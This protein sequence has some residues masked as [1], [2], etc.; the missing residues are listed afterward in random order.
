MTPLEDALRELPRLDGKSDWND[1]E[2]RLARLRPARIARPRRRARILAFAFA[3]ICF[4]ATGAVLA[5]S[6]SEPT[7]AVAWESAHEDASAT[8]PWADPWVAAAL[9]TSR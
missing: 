5:W 9:E 3:S 8:D 6:F 1:L 4:L 2:T 7:T